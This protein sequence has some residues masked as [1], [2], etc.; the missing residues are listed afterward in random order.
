MPKILDDTIA[1]YKEFSDKT[2]VA[3]RALSLGVLGVGWLVVTGGD[4]SVVMANVLPR[5]AVLIWLA[6]AFAITALILDAAQY[7]VTTVNAG[8]YYEVLDFLFKRY[9]HDVSGRRQKK[10][11]IRADEYGLISLIVAKGSGADPQKMEGDAARSSASAILNQLRRDRAGHL[12]PDD[13]PDRATMRLEAALDESYRSGGAIAASRCLFASK[14]V[15]TGVAGLCLVAYL[16]WVVMT[17]PT[18]AITC[19]AWSDAKVAI[20]AAPETPADYHAPGMEKLANARALQLSQG[21]DRLERSITQYPADVASASQL[22]VDKQRLE[23]AKLRS[24]Q[25]LDAIEVAAIDSARAGVDR[26]CR[27]HR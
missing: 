21:V 24:G 5:T 19:A 20:G 14:T 25:R 16:F 13:S 22:F 6:L 18:A 2:S 8:R 17:T 4:K 3:I 12:V 23:I 10:L 27:T 26:V 15:A 11:W 9:G 7:F 1:D